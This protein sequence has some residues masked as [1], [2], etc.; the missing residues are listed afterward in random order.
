MSIFITNLLKCDVIDG[1]NKNT[2]FHSFYK[3][4]LHSIQLPS[5]FTVYMISALEPVLSD[6]F[7]SFFLTVDVLLSPPRAHSNYNNLS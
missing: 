3:L 5:W 2:L 6:S 7:I 4:L 1:Y